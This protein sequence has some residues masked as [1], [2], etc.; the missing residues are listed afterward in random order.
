MLWTYYKQEEVLWNTKSRSCRNKDVRVAVA[1]KRIVLT[2]PT[3]RT[4]V[5]FARLLRCLFVATL[6]I[7]YGANIVSR[8]RGVT[9]SEEGGKL[10]T[11]P[12]PRTDPRVHTSLCVRYTVSQKANIVRQKCT[13]YQLMYTR[14]VAQRSCQGLVRIR[15]I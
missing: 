4:K 1:T 3:F 9:R 15:L 11:C 6:A 5:V 12:G 10:G 8:N 7:I 13:K 14:N 2:V